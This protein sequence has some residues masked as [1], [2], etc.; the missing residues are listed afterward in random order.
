M[1][2]SVFEALQD[3]AVSDSTRGVWADG[4]WRSWKACKVAADEA[5]MNLSQAGIRRGHIVAVQLPNS[6]AMVVIAAA[7]SKLGASL[8]PI[9]MSLGTLETVALLTQVEPA[10]FIGASTYRGTDR[11][12]DV[13][14]M[15]HAVP[16]MRTI[17]LDDLDKVPALCVPALSDAGAW[18]D[19]PGTAILLVSS[20]TTSTR[21]RICVH[22]ETSLLLNARSVARDAGHASTDVFLAGGQL[23][24]A[25]GLLSLHL[26]L[27]TGGS[28]GLFTEWGPE[29]FLSTIEGCEAT[30]LLAVPTQLNDLL[31]TARRNDI[32][33]AATTLREVRTGGAS[34][35]RPLC[36]AIRSR[37]GAEV[38][39]QWGMTEI[40]AGAVLRFGDSEPDDLY[41]TPLP[42]SRARVA[43]G[44]N[45]EL[46]LGELE[47]SSPWIAVGYLGAGR[48]IESC[49]LT[50]DGWLRTGDLAQRRGD[51]FALEGR[52]DD[53][54]N[55]GGLKFSAV[56]I[57][58][59]LADMPELC[60]IAIVAKQDERLGE[61]AILFATHREVATAVTL[62]DVVTHLANKGVAKYK[63]PEEL[64]ILESLPM[65][66]SGKIAKGE[67]RAKLATIHASEFR[68]STTARSET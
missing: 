36:E 47:F 64:F 15:A 39:V 6:W 58:Q 14:K 53:R 16:D 66:P 37:T 12:A 21:P 32:D 42:G 29:A 23:S 38:V 48:Q 3:V 43:A 34:V 63:F 13:S 9:H 44:A 28:L 25:F 65:T 33:L 5:S 18:T 41:V 57:E 4:R 17:A 45:E 68:P 19:T 11:R 56:E 49:E 61:R 30:R 59:H 8:L 10:L 54:I 2:L 46:R 27:V 60:A 35:S 1:P 7:L 20:G 24:H 31:E 22:S 26:A 55:R 51:S 67:L 62:Q 52:R 50:P 40:G